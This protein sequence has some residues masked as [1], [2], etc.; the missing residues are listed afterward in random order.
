MKKW[1]KKEEDFIK[2]NYRTMTYAEG[3]LWKEF[4]K[5]KKEN[6]KYKKQLELWQSGNA[7]A[8]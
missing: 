1:E 7:P 5:I 8:C 3:I 6:K 2:N 4:Q